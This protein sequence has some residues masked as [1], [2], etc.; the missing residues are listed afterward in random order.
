MKKL[1][2]F[3]IAILILGLMIESNAQSIVFK[4]FG[5]I[6]KSTDIIELDSQV[7]LKKGKW[8]LIS[9][10]SFKSGSNEYNTAV[11]QMIDSTKITASFTGT[12]HWQYTNSNNG[13]PLSDSVFMTING[14]P[15]LSSIQNPVGKCFAD[16]KFDLDAPYPIGCNPSNLVLQNSIIRYRMADKRRDTLINTDTSRPHWFYA[17]R[18]FLN[19]LYMPPFFNGDNIWIIAKDRQTGCVDSTQFKVVINP[20]PIVLL[21]NR[22]LCQDGGS[23]KANSNLLR[24]TKAELSGGVYTWTIVSTPPGI[25]AADKDLLLHNY[26]T[27]ASPDYVFNPN[28]L[29]MNMPASDTR[30]GQ[31]CYTLKFCII[32]TTSSCTTCDTAKLCIERGPGINFK[33]FDKFCYSDDTIFLDSYANLQYGRWELIRFNIST[34][35]SPTYN[36]IVAK[37]I[38]STAINVNYEPGEYYWRYVNVRNGCPAKDSVQ[39]IVNKEPI[40]G[41]NTLDTICLKNGSIDLMKSLVQPSKADFNKGGVKTGWRG[42]GVSNNTFYPDSAIANYNYP[43]YSKPFILGVSYQ[44]PNTLCA[45]H[46]SI[47]VVIKNTFKFNK[48]IYSIDNYF[49]AHEPDASYQWIDCSNNM[50]IAGETNRAY[51]PKLNGQYAV[52]LT[53]GNCNTDTSYCVTM[54]NV[55]VNQLLNKDIHVYP[56]P[57]NDVFY[58]KSNTTATNLFNAKLY[59]SDAKL[60]KT[61]DA[62]AMSEAIAFDYP[63][64]IY[65]LVIET[66]KGNLVVKVMK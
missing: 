33:P 46:D 11:Q 57:V 43:T 28:A 65:W 34:N 56:N 48:G 53:A 41:V 31:G 30:R 36:R 16:G 15:N 20:N 66:N 58:I 59:A 4:P 42:E 61:F 60:L 2:I 13:N 25:T 17:D 38:D 6:C 22:T 40:L 45:S 18:V 55:S 24:P 1:S 23:I 29:N 3:L 12:Y 32:D 49:Y 10:D 27:T 47:S 14:L 63:T 62:H 9:I 35:G 19:G 7:N 52:I 54:K 26:G 64:G 5:K 50:P 39:M 51:T 8:E 37:M 21:Q 44:D